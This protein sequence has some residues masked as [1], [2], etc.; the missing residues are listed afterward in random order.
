MN[1]RQNSGN[2]A[3][4]IFSRFIS[5]CIGGK[6]NIMFTIWLFSMSMVAQDVVSS[7]P[8]NDEHYTGGRAKPSMRWVSGLLPND[9]YIATTETVIDTLAAEKLFQAAKDSLLAISRQR[10][11]KRTRIQ[12][13]IDSKVKKV[14]TA[15][16]LRLLSDAFSHYRYP[17]SRTLSVPRLLIETYFPY[18]NPTDKIAKNIKKGKL[19]SSVISCLEEYNHVLSD[20]IQEIQRSVEL[21]WDE[22]FVAEKIPYPYKDIVKAI[23]NPYYRG[24]NYNNADTLDKIDGAQQR[25]GWEF[26]C[27]GNRQYKEDTYPFNVKYYIYD[28]APQ[29]KVVSQDL[30]VYDKKGQLVYVPSLTRK[31]T[32]EFEEIKRIVYLADYKNNKYNILSSPQRVQK[33]LNQMLG[34]KG[35]MESGY[36]MGVAMALALAFSSSPYA[37]ATENNL[38]P[39]QRGQL[40]DAYNKEYRNTEGE[41]F[42][43]QLTEDHKDEF[44]YI[45]MI[46]RVSNVGFRVIYINS[47]NLKP[48]YCALVTYKSGKKPYTKDFSVQFV[49]PPKN[50]PPAQRN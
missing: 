40:I 34:K 3:E 11:E 17:T 27:N 25:K 30:T 20:S 21:E 42:I 50:I 41:R 47:R 32:H 44:G 10:V 9:M 19:T 36:Y 26:L 31:N 35:E 48:S 7:R 24:Y 23:R 5:I 15:E 38:N 29:Y 13:L 6:M 45:Y 39:R 1:N 43:K 49:N 4:I 8:Q 37:Y 46:E 18:R 22:W 28:K 16:D 12:E 2:K 14:K 33:Y